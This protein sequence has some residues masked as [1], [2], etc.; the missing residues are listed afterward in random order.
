MSAQCCAGQLACCCGSAG[1]SLC[2][3]CCPKIRQSR[4][5]RFMYALYFILVVL[6]CCVM[7]SRT[8]ATE[9]KEHVSPP[10]SSP[11]L[12]PP[13]P[14]AEE[15]VWEAFSVEDGA[16]SPWCGLRSARVL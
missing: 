5:T 1:C 6:L 15:G 4:S 11:P 2:C 12:P 10:L 9:M 16:P 13:F 14:Q 8:V 3:D 7:M